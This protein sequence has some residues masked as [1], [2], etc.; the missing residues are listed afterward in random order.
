MT[1]QIT[2]VVR[3]FGTSAAETVALARTVK[4]MLTNHSFE[5]FAEPWPHFVPS[6]DTLATTTDKLD[7]AIKNAQ[8]RDT[9]KLAE[10]N[11][12]HLET[13]THLAKIA[14]YVE[15]AADGNLE[16]LRTTGFP[17]KSEMVKAAPTVPST[18]LSVRHALDSGFFDLR[19][20]R[21]SG[22]RAYDIQICEGDPA[23]ESNWSDVDTFPRATGIKVGE[24]EPGKLY[25]FRVRVLSGHGRG[26]WSVPVSLRAL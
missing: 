22:A 6:L 24:K 13:K 17:L 1:P 11:A 7:A 26:P 16:V 8:T 4:A 19:A 2:W 14:S 15:L 5:N 18:D 10:R 12:L 21:V 20:G 3:R 9:L 25:W 23:V